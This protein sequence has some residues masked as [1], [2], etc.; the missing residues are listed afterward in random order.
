MNARSSTN[1]SSTERN[2][3]SSGQSRLIS[4]DCLAQI[5]PR[6]AGSQKRSSRHNHDDCSDSEWEKRDDREINQSLPDVKQNRAL[7]HR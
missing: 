1:Q 7:H 2:S 6:R 4:R 3:V 5:D